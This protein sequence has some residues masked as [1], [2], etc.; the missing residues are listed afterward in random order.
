MK[1]IVRRLRKIESGNAYH[2]S[3]GSQIAYVM[4]GDRVTNWY[5]N[6]DGPEAADLIEL[7]AAVIKAARKRSEMD[8]PQCNCDLCAALRALDAMEA[9]EEW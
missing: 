6:P 5:R 3:D 1:D 9:E 2:S 8:I 4:G 7:Q